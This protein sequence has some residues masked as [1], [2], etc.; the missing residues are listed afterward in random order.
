MGSNNRFDMISEYCGNKF[1]MYLFYLFATILFMY[2]KQFPKKKIYGVQT[3]VSKY[4]FIL[5][6]NV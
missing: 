3:V 4:I 2:N 6:E 5:D 1:A